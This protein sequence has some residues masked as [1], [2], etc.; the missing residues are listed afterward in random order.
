MN[1]TTLLTL[2]SACLVILCVITC[3][4]T[5]CAISAKKI[6]E[7]DR[8]KDAFI[9][10]IKTNQDPIKHFG[11]WPEGFMMGVATAAFQN[12]GFNPYSTWAEWTL[13]HEK[14]RDSPL[15][16]CDA[17]NN[18]EGIDV[19][20]AE[21]LG[22]NAFRLSLDWARIE[23]KRGKFNKVA[24]KRYIG[25]VNALQD[26][27]IEPVITLVHFGLPQWTCGW[28]NHRQMAKEFRIFVDYVCASFSSQ[29][30]RHTFPKYW[31]TINEPCIDAIN[32][33]ML[34]TRW[35][36][37]M[38]GMRCAARA[39]RGMWCS[40]NEAFLA[41]KSV[42]ET[43]E[44]SIAKNTML[45]RVLNRFSPMDYVLNKGVEHIYNY[46]F[47]QA[48]VTGKFNIL[49][50][51]AS[52]PAGTLTYLGVNFYNVTRVGLK[53][54]FGDLD[55]LMTSSDHPD[56]SHINS[57]GWEMRPASIFTVLQTM[58][59]KF[60]LPILITE[61]GNPDLKNQSGYMC[62]QLYCVANAL[63][64]GIPVLGYMHWTLHDSFEWGEGFMGRFG[65]YETDFEGLRSSIAQKTDPAVHFK[66][67][68][69]AFKFK[70]LAQ[71]IVKRSAPHSPHSPSSQPTKTLELEL[72]D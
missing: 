38:G 58:W 35:P 33:H 21:F 59:M 23:P 51:R 3:M 11:K 43:C 6:Q 53:G 49:G 60:K 64:L 22:C 28:E 47:I 65:L 30:N 20:N 52:G 37:K 67:R 61:A 18:F 72:I 57:M 17:W 44:V 12:E 19:K 15:Q 42:S 63:H 36:G 27:G 26:K 32:T 16:A 1:E 48:C 70:E 69:S 10:S 62:Q 13:N 66:P 50:V 31:V 45:P 8:L 14:V 40:H 7:S 4:C 39:M 46:A 34:G 54:G 9:E 55:V 25:M 2:V 68:E 71:H 56:P 5:L 41:L 24:M 29:H